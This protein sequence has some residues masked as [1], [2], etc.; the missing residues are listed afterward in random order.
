MSLMGR[1][2]SSASGGLPAP[3]LQR[4]LSGDESEALAVAT[5][6]FGDARSAELLAAKQSLKL[7]CRRRPL[8]RGGPGGGGV[9]GRFMTSGEAIS[10]SGGDVRRCAGRPA[11]KSDA[12]VSPAVRIC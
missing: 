2:D 7:P 1:N 12:S 8:G 9:V 4:R 5:R 10:Y 11:R 3:N 6:P